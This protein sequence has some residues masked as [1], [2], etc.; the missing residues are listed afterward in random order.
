MTA[1]VNDVVSW[2]EADRQ[3]RTIAAKR[4]GL[5]A[6]EARWLMIAKRARVHEQLG[7][8]SFREYVERVLQLQPHTAIDRIRVAEALEEL[9]EIRDALAVAVCSY[10]AVRELTRIATPETEVAWLEA[11]AGRCVR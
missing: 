6:D 5:D 7:F 4:A 9:P 11:T 8:G 1:R 3:L 10:S 2:K